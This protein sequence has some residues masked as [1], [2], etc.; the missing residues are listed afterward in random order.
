MT[1]FIH[2]IRRLFHHDEA[3]PVP[4]ALL[5]DIGLPRVLVYFS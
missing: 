2:F 3:S 1:N 5:R 4:D